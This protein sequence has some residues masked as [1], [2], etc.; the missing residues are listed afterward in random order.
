MDDSVADAAARGREQETAVK[1][2]ERG[3]KKL[4]HV[5]A[6]PLRRWLIVIYKQALALVRQAFEMVTNL[7]K[8]AG[9][10]VGGKDNV[11]RALIEKTRICSLIKLEKNFIQR[12]TTIPSKISSSAAASASAWAA[13]AEEEERRLVLLRL[14]PW[15]SR[16]P[17]HL[18]LLR[19]ILLNPRIS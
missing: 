2:L 14:P 6:E 9:G 10:V 3:K 1:R 16:R 11:I 15:S 12:S 8:T 18:L 19:L 4:L 7:E 17:T 13:A 5:V